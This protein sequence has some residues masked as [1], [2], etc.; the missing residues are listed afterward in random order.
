MKI[1]VIGS[2]AMGSLYGGY[3]SQKNEVY[4]LDV[5]EEHINTINNKG[6]IIDENDGSSSI[7]T[8]RAFTKA[9][10][11][12]VVDLAIVFVKSIMT[13]AAMEANKALIGKDTIV[14]TLQNGY[15]NGDDIM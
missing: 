14:M 5:W 7:F 1:S 9:E 12:G 10:D 15:G 2:G 3:L 11:I 6:L 8:P 13:E 4:L